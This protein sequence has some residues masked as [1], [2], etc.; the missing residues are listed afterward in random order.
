[1][2]QFSKDKESEPAVYDFLNL[3]NIAKQGFYIIEWVDC[4]NGNQVIAAGTNQVYTPA[5]AGNYA[6]EFD[7]GNCTQMSAGIEEIDF[8]SALIVYPNPTF[9]SF[10]MDI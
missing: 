4:E 5:L 10:K 8:G 1:M 6:I 9:Y 3:S 7:N 2:T